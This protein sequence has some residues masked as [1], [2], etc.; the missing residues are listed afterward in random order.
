LLLKG[1]I[2][3]RKLKYVYKWSVNQYRRDKRT[4]AIDPEPRSEYL[5][6]LFKEE[7]E[8]FKNTDKK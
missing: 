2:E 6:M 4:G 3:M 8:R 5:K 1:A 7:E